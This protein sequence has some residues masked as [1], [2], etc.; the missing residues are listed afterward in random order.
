MSGWSCSSSCV[1]K[2]G[3]PDGGGVTDVGSHAGWMPMGVLV[4]VLFASLGSSSY[5]LITLLG[6]SI[7][8]VGSGVV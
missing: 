7:E 1:E 8:D 5:P 3:S 6:V 2:R 4:L